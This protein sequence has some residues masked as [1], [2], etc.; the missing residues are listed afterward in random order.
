MSYFF[1]KANIRTRL[2]CYFLGCVWVMVSRTPGEDDEL[3]WVCR[4]CGRKD[5]T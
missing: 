3:V 4:R 2:H 1:E 5:G